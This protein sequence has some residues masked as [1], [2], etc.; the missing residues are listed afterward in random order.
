[1]HVKHSFLLFVVVITLALGWVTPA[2]ANHAAQTIP[3]VVQPNDT[4]ASIAARNCTTWQHLYA[5]NR[6]VIGP[7]PNVLKSGTVIMVPNLCGGPTPGPTASP[8]PGGCNTGP[9][10]HVGPVCS[11]CGKWRR[12]FAA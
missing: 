3:Y 5:L 2:E 4:L 7:N 10:Q 8:G 6:G 12:L 1:M 9:T 11:V